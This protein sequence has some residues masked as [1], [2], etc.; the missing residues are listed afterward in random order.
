MTEPEPEEDEFVSVKVASYDGKAY[1]I[2]NEQLYRAS[3]AEDG[4][5]DHKTTE[6]VDSMTIDFEEMPLLFNIVEALKQNGA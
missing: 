3:L 6:A 4:N 2:I 1:W 5:I